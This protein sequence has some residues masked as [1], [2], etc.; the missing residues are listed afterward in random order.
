MYGELPDSYYHAYEREVPSNSFCVG[1]DF[2][3]NDEDE[4]ED[5]KLASEWD[6]HYSLERARAK[7]QELESLLFEAERRA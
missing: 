5:V 4:V 7:I 6:A 3:P 1:E 2:N